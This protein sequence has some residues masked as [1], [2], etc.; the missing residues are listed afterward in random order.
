MLYLSI[1]IIAFGLFLILFSLFVESKKNYSAVDDSGV[2]YFDYNPQVSKNNNPLTH[3]NNEPEMDIDLPVDEVM[4]DETILGSTVEESE[5]D[6]GDAKENLGDLEDVDFN[7]IETEDQ[8]T[9]LDEQAGISLQD[10]PD[11]ERK[12]EDFVA[13]LYEDFS[14][15]IEYDSN[16]NR[17]D[18]S[19][20]E[21]KKIKR[22]GEG[23]IKYESDGICFSTEKRF[24]RFDFYRVKDIQKGDNYIAIYLNESN[25]VRLFLFEKDTHFCKEAYH[26]FRD[27]QRGLS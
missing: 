27:Y 18:P 11:N 10:K 16:T 9:E 20:E 21:Y 25:V 14:N 1:I 4:K 5:K 13:F 24:Y 6:V 19:L 8:T 17:I 12:K 23:R 3:N 7:N 26:T 22:I 15:I 2:S